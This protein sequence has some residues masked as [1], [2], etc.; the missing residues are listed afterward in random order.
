M[1]CLNK[2]L[3]TKLQCWQ[4][5]LLIGRATPGPFWP[6][7][8]G[9]LALPASDRPPAVIGAAHLGVKVFNWLYFTK[10]GIIDRS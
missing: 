5:F 8:A 1:C 10:R 4:R 6:Q 7:A 9:A 3:F 2:P